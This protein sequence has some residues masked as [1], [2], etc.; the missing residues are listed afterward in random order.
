MSK[1]KNNPV[2]APVAKAAVIIGAGH[3]LMIR[4]GMNPGKD[5]LALPGGFLD[6]E[7]TFEQGMIRELKEETKIPPEQLR[8]SIQKWQFFDHPSRSLRGR[9]ITHAAYIPLPLK[10]GLPRVKGGD[11]AKEALWIPL[12][13][14]DSLMEEIYEDHYSIIRNFTG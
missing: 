11:D 1:T 14:L 3:V 10:N 7:E 5:C 12:S 6:P 4:R 9:I 13:S 2:M 8:T